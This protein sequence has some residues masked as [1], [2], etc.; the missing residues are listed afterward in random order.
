MW[1]GLTPDEIV[2]QS[3]LKAHGFFVGVISR[4]RVR[5]DLGAHRC[6]LGAV[7]LEERGNRPGDDP[8][9]SWEIREKLAVGGDGA[10]PGGDQGGGRK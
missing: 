8:G 4:G 10:G 1:P 2:H 6:L 7:G 5:T 9:W 3:I